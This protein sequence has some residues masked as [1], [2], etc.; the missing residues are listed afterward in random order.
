M[1]PD[2][3]LRLLKYLN[4]ALAAANEIDSATVGLSERSYY[5]NN[6]KWIVERGI[7]IISEALKRAS[8]ISPDLQTEI[9]DL[10]K[11]FATR[12]KIAHQYD[13]V[14]PLQ[15]Y[16]IVVKN[17]PVLMEELKMIIEKLEKEENEN[18]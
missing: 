12:N 15:L 9:T 10:S 2:L 3:R 6:I 11:I 4:D 16:S 1:Q 13:I 8:A 14:D 5:F 18:G 17:I 7:E